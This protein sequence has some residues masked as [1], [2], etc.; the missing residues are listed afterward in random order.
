MDEDYEKALNKVLKIRDE[1]QKIYGDSWKSDIITNYYQLKN[2]FE[3]I[4][5][6]IETLQTNHYESLIDQ[7]IDLT[8]YSLFCLALILKEK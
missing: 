8:N 6:M 3:R 4:K 2:K 1:R 5:I 7:F